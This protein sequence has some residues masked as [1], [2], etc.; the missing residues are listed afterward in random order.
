MA[1]AHT[2]T[3]VAPDPSAVKTLAD[4]VGP[5]AAVT[6]VEIAGVF[7]MIN[8]VMDATGSP[9]LAAKLER[10]QPVLELIG[11]ME[12]RDA[13]ESV[14]RKRKPGRRLRKAIHRLRG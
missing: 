3:L 6:A 2:A 9:V 7:G 4:T 10:A 1:L 14:V 5:A 13:D 12:F 11:A 8:R